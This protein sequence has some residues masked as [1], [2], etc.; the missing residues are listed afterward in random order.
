MFHLGTYVAKDSTV[1]ASH[2]QGEN[3]KAAW[4][5]GRELNIRGECL[6]G[7]AK[8]FPFQEIYSPQTREGQEGTGFLPGVCEDVNPAKLIDVKRV[9]H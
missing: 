1:R 7:P 6:M 4:Q 9:V 8:L 2:E 3:Q 5:E